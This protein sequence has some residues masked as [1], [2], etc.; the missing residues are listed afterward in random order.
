MKV[1]LTKVSPHIKMEQ[2][3]NLSLDQWCTLI[4]SGANNTRNGAR[5]TCTI[6]RDNF[7]T[8]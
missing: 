2:I 7:E 4:H 5:A 1:E 6:L 3:M 8:L